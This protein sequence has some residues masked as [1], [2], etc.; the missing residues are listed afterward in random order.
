M[1]YSGEARARH[2]RPELG[3]GRGVAGDWVHTVYRYLHRMCWHFERK[4]VSLENS[5]LWLGYN[6]YIMLHDVC[7]VILSLCPDILKNMP[8][9]Y[10]NQTYDLSNASPMLCQLS[11]TVRSVCLSKSV[12]CSGGH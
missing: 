10:E 2:R 7:G 12:N 8:D 3:P 9:C 4:P 1:G 5:E 6:I 11:Y